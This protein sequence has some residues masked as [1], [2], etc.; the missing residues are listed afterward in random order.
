M[1]DY[2]S[3]MF[4]ETAHFGGRVVHNVEQICD[5]HN[6][7][8]IIVSNEDNDKSLSEKLAENIAAIIHLFSGKLSEMKC[9]IV[10]TIDKSERK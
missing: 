10:K 8:I 7:K 2:S 4:P 3:M 1:L 5:F 9:K 6:A